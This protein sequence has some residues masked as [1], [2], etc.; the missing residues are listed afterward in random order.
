MPVSV[1]IENK[2]VDRNHSLLLERFSTRID[3]FNVRRQTLQDLY[4]LCDRYEIEIVRLPLRRL[5]GAAL[6]DAGYKYL[7]VNKHIAGYQQV[8]S[9]FHELTHHLD[10]ALGVEVF[11]STGNLWNLPKFELQAQLI[12][13]LC[14][15]P[16]TEIQGM[17]V[18]E[19]MKAH[20]IS[21]NLALFR[22][23]MGAER[24]N[25]DMRCGMLERTRL[26]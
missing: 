22:L 24:V 3:G 15:L 4:G 25:A 5:H 18:D 6:E 16:E 11:K 23:S 9:G 26:W 13:V 17:S 7:Y 20:A 14:W 1:Q 8:I 21:R 19:I 2:R 10:H 12:G